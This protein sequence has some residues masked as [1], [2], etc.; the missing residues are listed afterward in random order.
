MTLVS[1]EPNF[2]FHDG[3]RIVKVMMLVSQGMLEGFLMPR[4]AGFE[5]SESPE[6]KEEH[7]LEVAPGFHSHLGPSTISVSKYVFFF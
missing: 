1:R 2:D 5:P 7:T 4:V 6:F 3:G